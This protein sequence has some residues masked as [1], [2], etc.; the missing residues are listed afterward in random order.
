MNDKYEFTGENKICFGRTLRRIRATRDIAG[1][2]VAARDLG[3]WIENE[4]NLSREGNAWVYGN[5]WVSGDAR[6]YGD[7]L[8]YGDARVSGVNITATRSDGYTFLVTPTPEG[9]R[10]IA[11]CR[12]FTFHKAEAY[13]TRTRG[14]TKLGDESLSIVKHLKNMAELNGFMV[15]VE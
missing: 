14:G 8:V 1:P 12:Y 6:V 3:G 5:A 4:S 2:G 15:P 9:P 10:V 11:G 7:A 13:W